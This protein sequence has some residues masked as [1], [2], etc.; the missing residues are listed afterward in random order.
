MYKPSD[1]SRRDKHPF[2]FLVFQFLTSGIFHYATGTPLMELLCQ[3]ANWNKPLG[4]GI[5]HSVASDMPDT[6]FQSCC[7]LIWDFF[8]KIN[9]SIANGNK[10]SPSRQVKIK[11]EDFFLKKQTDL[12]KSCSR[13]EH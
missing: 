4:T 11:L 12:L 6:T 10:I 1:V 3:F 13:N 2:F 7:L 5:F 9:T 8:C